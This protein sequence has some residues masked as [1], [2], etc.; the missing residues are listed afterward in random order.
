MMYL[1][2]EKNYGL[3]DVDVVETAEMA[4]FK[5]KENARENFL[6]RVKEYRENDS[7]FTYQPDCSNEN[8][9]YFAFKLDPANGSS[10][11]GVEVCLVSLPVMDN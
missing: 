6:A 10:E 3:N 11:G 5:S 4:L 9:A 8:S 7:D 1:V 2:Y